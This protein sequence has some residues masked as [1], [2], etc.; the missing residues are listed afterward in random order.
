MANVVI[1]NC[2]D[3][4]HVVRFGFAFAWRLKVFLVAFLGGDLI[5]WATIIPAI[6]HADLSSAAAPGSGVGRGA[7]PPALLPLPFVSA[8]EALAP[9]VWDVV[10]PATCPR[11]T[12]HVRNNDQLRQLGLDP[13]AVADAHLEQAYGRLEARAPLLAQRYAIGGVCS[14]ASSVIVTAGCRTWAPRAA[15]PPPGASAAIAAS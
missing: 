5:I 8:L 3:N 4:V 2:A 13:P 10:E 7:L 9:E 12:L 11:A 15:A 6:Y 1:I 14:T